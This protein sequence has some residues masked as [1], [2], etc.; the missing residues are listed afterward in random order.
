MTAQLRCRFRNALHVFTAGV[1]ALAAFIPADAAHAQRRGGGGGRNGPQIL[2]NVPYDGRFTYVRIRYESDGFSR[3]GAS[4]LHDY[5]RGEQHFEKIISELSTIRTFST[6]S[7]ILS[8]SDPQLTKYPVAFMAEPGFWRPNDLEVIGLRNYLTKGGF[9]IFDDFADRDWGNFEA[10]MQKVFPK[11]RAIEMTLDHPIFDS[12]YK[13]KTLKYNHPY[14]GFPSVFLGYFEDNDPKKRLLAM[15]NYNNDL[16]E[17]WEF[18]DTG[19]FP[20]DASNE[21]YKLGVNYIIYALTR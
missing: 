10:Q 5:P 21:A 12:F 17:Y 8:L 18:S 16:S 4:W 2:P 14:Y 11:L 7:N 3:G 19:M 20:M 9:I 1:M 13:I 15:V 6:G